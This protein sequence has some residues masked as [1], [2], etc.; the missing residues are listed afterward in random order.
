MVRQPG[1]YFRW[2][3]SRVLYCFRVTPSSI[4][5]GGIYHQSSD[6]TK[7]THSHHQR[8][9]DDDNASIVPNSFNL[10][11]ALRIETSASPHLKALLVVFR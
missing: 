2:S 11:L 8:G 4:F 6:E 5:G 9:S 1:S 10:I 3:G 7:L